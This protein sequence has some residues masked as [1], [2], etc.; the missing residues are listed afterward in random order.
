MKP[1]FVYQNPDQI[2]PRRQYII[3]EARVI[4]VNLDVSCVVLYWKLENELLSS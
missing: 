3:M 2:L 1:A 4:H